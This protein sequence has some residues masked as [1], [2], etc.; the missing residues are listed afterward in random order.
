MRQK[1]TLVILPAGHCA[2]WLVP[3]V[4]TCQTRLAGCSR[5]GAPFV[6][7]IDGSGCVE[8]PCG[9]TEIG[10][11]PQFPTAGTNTARR[12]ETCQLHDF[13]CAAAPE[14]GRPND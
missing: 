10:Y 8:P 12:H 1:E 13:V 7:S 4:R 5:R 14:R 6:A 3:R 2:L 11:L 9:H